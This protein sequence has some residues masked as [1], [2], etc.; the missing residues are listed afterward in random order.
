MN[1]ITLEQLINPLLANTNVEIYINGN[2]VWEG[3][4]EKIPKKY[5]DKE[6]SWYYPG[7][8]GD[9]QITIK[10]VEFNEIICD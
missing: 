9:L 5:L 10:G 2:W 4:C 6:V 3:Y 1:N 7:D 8:N